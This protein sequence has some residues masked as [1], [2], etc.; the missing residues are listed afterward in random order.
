MSQ[1]FGV[2]IYGIDYYGYSQPAD[3]SVAPFTAT[4]TDYGDITLSWASPNTTSWK[5]MELVRST[6]GYPNRPEDGVVLT[7]I[8]PS[9][10]IRTYDDPGLDAGTIYYYAM[11]IS[12]E[13]PAWSSSTTYA[14]NAQ[15]LYNGFYWSS[16]QGS[17][18]NHAPSAGSAYW[19][20]SNY[21]P[22]WYPAGF[23]ATL[24]IGNQ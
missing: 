21:V 16:L 8:V 7:T 4:Q 1:G 11:F 5:V 10:M 18:T 15:V 19:T 14:L 9:G 17:N 13:A 12:L 22:T 6:Y 20:S 3:Y 2:D 24:A 23:A